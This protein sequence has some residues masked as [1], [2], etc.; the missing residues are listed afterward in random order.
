MSRSDQ[1]IIDHIRRRA[2]ARQTVLLRPETALRLAAALHAVIGSDRA[3]PA[4][5]PAPEPSLGFIVEELAA[6]GSATN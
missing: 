6:T 4:R 2:H 5:R 1:A 3:L